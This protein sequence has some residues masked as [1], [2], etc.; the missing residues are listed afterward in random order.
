ML[1]G[2]SFNRKKIELN[3][4]AAFN[5]QGTGAVQWII[6]LPLMILPMAIFGILN[7]F[8]NFEIAI[9]VIII[10]GLLGIAFHQKIMK[11]ITKKYQDSK[12]KMIDA[13]SQDN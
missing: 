9:G 2:G 1:Y 13:F 12:Y 8:I 4:K 7:Y 5:F 3:Q 10:L 6:G 11:F